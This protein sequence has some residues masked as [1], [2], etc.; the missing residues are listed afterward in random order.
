MSELH[1]PSSDE[2]A[3]M[4]VDDR[5][6]GRRDWFGE[7]KRFEFHSIWSR[8]L[9]R[10]SSTTDLEKK[11]E[12]NSLTFDRQ[13][14][15]DCCRGGISKTKKINWGKS[16]E[17]HTLAIA[18]LVHIILDARSRERKNGFRE[19]EVDSTHH[20]LT[21]VFGSLSLIDLKEEEIDL[22][23]AREEDSTHFWSRSVFRSSLSIELWKGTNSFGERE[24]NYTHFRWRRLFGSLSTI[25]LKREEIDLEKEREVNLRGSR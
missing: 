17:L 19:T 20:H 5:S 21:R 3:Q 23:R 16:S 10:S 7:T 9:F 24:A 25:D 18:K 22:E 8:R 6:K 1:S 14:S 2:S 13:P 4:I 15:S 12:W 11:D